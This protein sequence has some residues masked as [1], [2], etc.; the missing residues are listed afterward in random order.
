MKVSSRDLPPSS[1]GPPEGHKPIHIVQL[2][3]FK[4]PG[5][6]TAV[7]PLTTVTDEEGL[8]FSHMEVSNPNHGD[9]WDC[10]SIGPH[11]ILHEL[12]HC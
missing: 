4:E 7:R 9:P 2:Q 6:M 5:N 1:G 8:F 12:H 11:V 3:G 10:G